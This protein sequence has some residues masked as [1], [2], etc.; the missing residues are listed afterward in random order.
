MDGA[1]ALA[2]LGSLLRGDTASR[3][4]RRRAIRQALP[5]LQAGDVIGT[6]VVNPLYGQVSRATG[7]RVSHVGIVFPAANGGWEVAESKFPVVTFTPLEDFILRSQ[8]DWFCVRRPRHALSPDETVRLRDACER[9]RGIPYDAW[10]RFD[11]RLQYCSK[12]VYQAFDEATGLRVGELTTFGELRRQLPDVPL[13]FWRLW[14]GGRIPWQTRTVTP[15][16]I[17][18]AACMCRVTRC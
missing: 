10:F 6:A 13:A 18:H 17:M 12:L 3:F 1:M 5:Q 2:Q 14:Y 11:G 15:A 16:S 7:S 8:Q 4:E 9:R